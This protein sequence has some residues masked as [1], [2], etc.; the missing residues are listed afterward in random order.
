MLYGH[1]LVYLV[2]VVSFIFGV[3]C[4]WYFNGLNMGRLA[5]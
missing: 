2:L 4:F 3:S 1:T 5:F